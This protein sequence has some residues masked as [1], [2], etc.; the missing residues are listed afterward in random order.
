MNWIKHIINIAL[1]QSSHKR[2]QM[3]FIGLIL[4]ILVGLSFVKWQQEEIYSLPLLLATGSLFLL[5]FK[6][7]IVKPILAGWLV[8][9]GLLGEVSSFIILGFLYFVFLTPA[10]FLKKKNTYKGNWKNV[11]I[12]T[13]PLKNLY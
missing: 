2:K 6:P 5:L 1:H 3:Q 10:S 11:D 12:S 4:I 8:L 7:I 9:G 13:K